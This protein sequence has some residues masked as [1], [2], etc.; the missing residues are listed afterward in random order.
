ME[1][2]VEGKEKIS[3]QMSLQT[4]TRTLTVCTREGRGDYK[5]Q[6][7]QLSG[8]KQEGPAALGPV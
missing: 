6:V 7:F 3:E 1:L 5:G 2:T 8:L 4:R